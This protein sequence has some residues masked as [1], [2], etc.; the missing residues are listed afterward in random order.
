MFGSPRML[1]W[2]TLGSA[3]VAA[4]ILVTV[5]GEWWTL[6]I[7]LAIHALGTTLVLTGVFKVLGERDKPD[8]VTQARM[9]DEG[10]ENTATS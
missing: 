7:P 4:A 1:L 10:E 3:V 6:L 8:P 9:D 2:M 5:T